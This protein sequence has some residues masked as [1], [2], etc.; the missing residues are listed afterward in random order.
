MT[1]GR[2][3]LLAWLLPWRAGWYPIAGPCRVAAVAAWTPGNSVAC[4]DVCQ[5]TIPAVCA[6]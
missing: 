1:L 3:D 4:A 5:P 6:D 2:W